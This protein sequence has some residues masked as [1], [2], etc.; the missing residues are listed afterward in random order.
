MVA[1]VESL[2]MALLTQQDNQST[3]GPVQT[4]AKQRSANSSV[5]TTINTRQ[6]FCL[7]STYYLISDDYIPVMMI[8]SRDDDSPPVSDYSDNLMYHF[9]RFLVCILSLLA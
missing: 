9:I 3:A 2:K 5:T 1:E 7:A 8:C 6:P 4:L